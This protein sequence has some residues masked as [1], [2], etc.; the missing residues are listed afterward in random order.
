[1]SAPPRARPRAPAPSPAPCA[2]PWSG[3]RLCPS[4]YLTTHLPIGSALSMA[5]NTQP[6]PLRAFPGRPAALRDHRSPP[7][8]SIR[9]AI[10]A[11][12]TAR[13]SAAPGAGGRSGGGGGHGAPRRRGSGVPQ[14]TEEHTAE[15]QSRIDLVCPLLPQSKH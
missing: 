12:A 2:P 14:R 15:T 6:A 9:N 5:D 11:T 3:R 1:P 10:P 7:T 4:L 8:R 13:E